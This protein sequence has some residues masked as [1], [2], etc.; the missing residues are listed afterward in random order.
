MDTATPP[1]A[2][3]ATAES[4]V[5][6]FN[7]GTNTYQHGPYKIAPKTICD[8]T[9]EASK[10]LLSCMEF[11][12]PAFVLAQ[13]LKGQPAAAPAVDPTLAAALSAE[14]QKTAEL[15]AQLNGLQKLLEG[16]TAPAPQNPVSSVT[17]VVTPPAGP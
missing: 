1:A 16:L 2:P 12:S 11:G 10:V 14:Q 6:V 9:V 3:A 15:Q 4:L 8:V 5:S 17:A 13:A 7:Q